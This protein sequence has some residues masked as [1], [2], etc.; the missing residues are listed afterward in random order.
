MLALPFFYF[1][2]ESAGLFLLL[3]NLLLQ[4]SN[5]LL[6][7]PE[8]HFIVLGMSHLFE[9]LPALYFPELASFDAHYL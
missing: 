6:V 2:I 7:S 1:F 8:N 4:R 9:Q 5:D 3:G